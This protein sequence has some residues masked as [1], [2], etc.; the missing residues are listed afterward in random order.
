M[1]H[2]KTL[3][4]IIS[5]FIGVT[6]VR[7]GSC[8]TCSYQTYIS[9]NVRT[10]NRTH[11]D[12]CIS[13]PSVVRFPR[14]LIPCGSRGEASSRRLSKRSRKIG[15]SAR[16]LAPVVGKLIMPRE[17]NWHWKT[18]FTRTKNRVI[19]VLR[20]VPVG[21]LVGRWW[22]SSWLKFDRIEFIRWDDTRRWTGEMFEVGKKDF[23][24]NKF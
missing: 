22:F 16:P 1:L 8:G 4:L 11:A 13:R 23:W 9:L 15:N 10:A 19:N 21:W 12:T 24:K 2:R 3:L 18:C 17:I 14:Y 7:E 5:C 20:S 6:V